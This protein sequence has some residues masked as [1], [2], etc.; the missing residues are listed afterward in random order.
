MNV[1]DAQQYLRYYRQEYIAEQ[2]PLQ[3]IKK[4]TREGQGNVGISRADYYRDPAHTRQSICT[5]GVFPSAQ[6]ASL[7]EIPTH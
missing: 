6:I 7:W 2:Q 4:K 1:E 3:G 5:D